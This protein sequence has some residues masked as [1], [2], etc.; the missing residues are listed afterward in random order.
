MELASYNKAL[1]KDIKISESKRKQIKFEL[2]LLKQ[3]E[4]YVM[5]YIISLA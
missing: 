5:R 4:K 3:N 2:D 1:E